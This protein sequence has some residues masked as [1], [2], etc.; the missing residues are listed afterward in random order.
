L[1]VTTSLIPKDPLTRKLI[2]C[3]LAAMIRDD[4]WKMKAASIAGTLAAVEGTQ[5]E[6]PLQTD[7][8]CSTKQGDETREISE[9]ILSRSKIN[10]TH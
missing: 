7:G 5:A 6:E 1:K 8:V 10:D 9:V 4:F 3:V 2:A